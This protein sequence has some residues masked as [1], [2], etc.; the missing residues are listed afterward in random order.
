MEPIKIINSTCRGGDAWEWQQISLKGDCLQMV[1]IGTGRYNNSLL[2]G[3]FA[4]MVIIGQLMVSWPK[5]LSCKCL[6]SCSQYDLQEMHHSRQGSYK[7]KAVSFFLWF[8][9]VGDYNP[10]PLF[11]H[12]SSYIP[13]RKAS[14]SRSSGRMSAACKPSA[15]WGAPVVRNKTQKT[16]QHLQI[17]V[18]WHSKT[19]DL[20]H[21][22]NPQGAFEQDTRK[23]LYIHMGGGS[24]L[25]T[26]AG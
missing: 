2:R 1:H 16:S 26:V 10:S 13:D 5:C 8:Q 6:D 11:A 24:V 3:S 17:K 15:C 25:D 12:H 19:Y 4:K 20:P 18:T 7:T 9:D 21:L 14:L 23:K 22:A